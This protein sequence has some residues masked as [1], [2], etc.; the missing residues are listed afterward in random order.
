MVDNR[1]RR[2]KGNVF[3]DLDFPPNEAEHLRV[4]AD[5]M[6]ALKERKH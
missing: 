3:R 2:S 6:I 5:L 1:I 4:R